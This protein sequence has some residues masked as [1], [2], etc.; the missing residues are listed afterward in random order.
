MAFTEFQG[1]VLT[2]HWRDAPPVRIEYWR[3]PTLGQE[4]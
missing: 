4:K 2:R 1:F 3:Q